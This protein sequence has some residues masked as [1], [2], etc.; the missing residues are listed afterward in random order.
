MGNDDKYEYLPTLLKNM[1]KT[2]KKFQVR[3]NN[4][5]CIH[6]FKYTKG[7]IEHKA[8]VII[9]EISSVATEMHLTRLSLI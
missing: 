1:I 2:G 6:P 3:E 5:K 9:P 7:V 8:K 4:R